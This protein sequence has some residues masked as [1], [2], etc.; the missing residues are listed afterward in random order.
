MPSLWMIKALVCHNIGNVT[1]MAIYRPI[2]GPYRGLMKL[3]AALQ[4]IYRDRMKDFCMA[5]SL[6][7]RLFLVYRSFMHTIREQSLSLASYSALRTSSLW[8]LIAFQ[9]YSYNEKVYRHH[10]HWR[11]C[12]ASLHHIGRT[13]KKIATNEVQRLAITDGSLWVWP[14]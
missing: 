10:R 14:K 7:R 9:S 11:Q 13:F 1:F 6:D 5:S 4:V 3:F 12:L 8:D 2:Y